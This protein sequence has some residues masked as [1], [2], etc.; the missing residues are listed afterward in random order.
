MT[1]RIPT[2]VNAVELSQYIMERRQGDRITYSA[3]TD[4]TIYEI[5]ERLMTSEGAVAK[6]INTQWRPDENTE[7]VTWRKYG[8][9][10]YATTY[11]RRYMFNKMLTPPAISLL[12]HPLISVEKLE[13]IVGTAFVDLVADANYTE[14]WGGAYYIDYRN[15]IIEFRGF[16]PKF[17]TPIKIEYT[18]GRQEDI[19]GYVIASGTVKTNATIETLFTSDANPDQGVNGLYNGKL[20]KFTS[21]ALI[22]DTYRITSSTYSDLTPDKISTF[23]LSG[24]ELVTDGLLQDDTYDVYAIP[25]DVQEMIKI[26]TYL[27]ILVA[28][29]TYQHNF[30]NPYDEPNPQ[31]TQFEWLASRFMNLQEQRKNTIQLLN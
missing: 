29:P 21:G 2:Y 19:D 17:R 28:D 7:E 26:Y 16:K 1:V 31:Y 4:P 20:I 15:G 8:H 23:T 27:G 12:Y 13:V 22:T 3:T 11:A 30:T 24:S 6:L 18:H 25:H 10:Y 5:N 9:P 14:A